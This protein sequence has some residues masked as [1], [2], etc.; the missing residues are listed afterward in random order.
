[1]VRDGRPG[2]EQAVDRARLVEA[3]RSAQLRLVRFL[4]CDTDGIV[5][6]KAAGTAQLAERLEAGIG[7]TVAM[8]AFTMLDRLAPVPGMGPVGEI[9]LVA[10]PTTFVVAPYAPHTAVVL[11]DMVTTAGQPYD[12]DG[13]YFLRR[14][15]ERAAAHDLAMTAAFEPEWSLARWAD[16]GQL[17]PFDHSLCFDS[18]GMDAAAEVIDEVI[19]ALEAQGMAVEQY[20]PELGHGQQELSIRHAPALQAADQHLLY[21]ETVRAV[22]RRHGLHA[23]LAPKPWPDQPGNG[24]HLHIS[25]LDVAGERQRFHDPAAADGLSE[26]GRRFAAGILDHL[27]GLV[28]LTC[29]SVNSYRRLLPQTWA[30]AFRVW[31]HDN[32]EAALR[33]VSPYWGREA[34]TVNLELKP[35]DAS[36]NPHLSLG[37]V[38]AAGVDG[39]ERGLELPA[40]TEVDPSTLEP[41][42]PRLPTSLAEALDGLERDPVLLDALG[43]RLAE[44]YLAVKRHDVDAFAAED[45]EFE[46][47]Q[48]RLRH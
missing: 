24:C 31:G 45:T 5:R 36:A 18:R 33:V 1:M 20:Y 16:E 39:I 21:R 27:P 4:Y 28:A 6:G 38:I 35:S 8:Q 26:T 12:A 37:A 19:G 23:T 48:H 10:D 43:G 7:L 9:R 46:F 41:A 3:A 32:R 17:V 40:P 11:V 30:S 42:P 29:A 14:M 34:A 47:R 15:V 13:R 22:A 25:A 44:C 2:P